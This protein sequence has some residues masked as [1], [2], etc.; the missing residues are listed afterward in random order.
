MG[1]KER[2][3]KR[4]LRGVSRRDVHITQSELELELKQAGFNL[5]EYSDSPFGHAVAK[6]PSR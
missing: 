2:E 6:R 5:I 3:I 1:P 4:R